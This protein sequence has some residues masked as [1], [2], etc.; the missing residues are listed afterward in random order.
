MRRSNTTGIIIGV[1]AAVVFVALV[2]VGAVATALEEA[3]PTESSWTPIEDSC[4][5]SPNRDLPMEWESANCSEG[6][7]VVLFPGAWEDKTRKI[8]DPNGRLISNNRVCDEGIGHFEVTY[9]DYPKHSPEDDAVVLG[10]EIDVL[11][12][13]HGC[14]PELERPITLKAPDDQ[15]FAGR[16]LSFQ[17]LDNRVRR[18]R[19]YIVKNRLFLVWAEVYSEKRAPDAMKFLTSFRLIGNIPQQGW[20]SQYLP[21][22][23]KPDRGTAVPKKREERGT[24]VPEKK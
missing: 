21:E 9:I 4:A 14:Q 24:A 7:Y 15:V 17:L 1:L 6:Q 18:Y 23:P 12:E 19:I 10:S 3:S 2:L 11:V 5:P 13:F 8:K 20:P 22:E 16:E